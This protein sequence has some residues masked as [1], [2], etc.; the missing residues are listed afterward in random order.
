M[1]DPNR[2]DPLLARLKVAWEKN[3]DLRLGQLL[4]NVY[5]DPVLYYVEDDELITAMEK[6]YGLRGDNND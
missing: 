4:M 3:P 5:R 1:R 6:L 2:I